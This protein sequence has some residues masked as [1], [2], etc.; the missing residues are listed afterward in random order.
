MPRSVPGRAAALVAIGLVAIGLVAASLSL[1]GAGAGKRAGVSLLHSNLDNGAAGPHAGG[2]PAGARQVTLAAAARGHN[3][4]GTWGVKPAQGVKSGF[5][6]RRPNQVLPHRQA[7]GVTSGGCLVGYGDPGAQCV[8]ARN[9][10]NRPLT[11]AYV[12]RLFPDG[13][14]VTAGD[15]RHLDVN[16][17]G[18]ACGPEDLS[19]SRQRG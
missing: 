14:R 13:V 7:T 2:D 16:R 1:V 17:D 19:A 10:G 3:G 4:I 15:P 9:P 5:V 18:R 12:A 6:Q 8:P 11:C